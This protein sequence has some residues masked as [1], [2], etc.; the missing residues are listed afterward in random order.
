MKKNILNKCRII[1]DN[2]ILTACSTLLI[3][4]VVLVT[5]QVFSRYVLNDPS[6][7]T[8]E[9]SR[10]FMIWLGFLGA[11]YLFGKRAH[12]AITLMLDTLDGY[13]KNIL[14]VVINLTTLTFVNLAM[15]RGGWLLVNK[16]LHQFSPALQIPMGYIY[17]ILPLS[18]VLI[19]VYIFL[20]FLDALTKDEL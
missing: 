14:L 9:L 17:F 5:W 3:A 11:C 7:F 2:S 19:T 15:L 8:D 18:A 4:L 10:Y 20:N 16:T 12:L 13:K 1:L 6:S